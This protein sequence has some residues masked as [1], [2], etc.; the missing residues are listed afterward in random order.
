[1]QIIRQVQES[2][3]DDPKRRRSPG[4]TNLDGFQKSSLHRA[5]HC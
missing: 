1:M 2:T 5:Y 4:A 3:E